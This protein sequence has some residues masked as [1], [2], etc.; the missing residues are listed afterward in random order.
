MEVTRGA[1]PLLLSRV[2]EGAP[3]PG[4]GAPLVEVLSVK[5]LESAERTALRCNFSDGEFKHQACILENLV[6]DQANAPATVV[7]HA[8]VQLTNWQL[9]L[10][11]TRSGQTKPVLTIERMVVL[12]TVPPEKRTPARSLKPAHGGPDLDTQCTQAVPETQPGHPSEL[13]PAAVPSV[14]SSSSVSAA[15]GVA[16][17]PWRVGTTSAVESD[18]AAA[19]IAGLAP[20]RGNQQLTDFFNRGPS[21]PPPGGSAAAAAAL[22]PPPVQQADFAAS[23]AAA[24]TARAAAVGGGAV[25]R[26]VQ[27]T[28]LPIR[29]LTPYQ[30]G[31]WRIKAR[32]IAKESIRRFTNSRGE[33]Q[34]FKVELVDKDGAEINATFFGRAVD[35]YFEMI[36]PMQVY[37]FS[38]GQVKAANKRFDKGDVVITFDDGAVI[39]VAE[40]DQGIRGV[41]YQFVPIAEI[42]QR[43]VQTDIDVKG[44]ITEVRDCIT[45]MLRTS[46]KERAKREIVL[47]DNSGGSP[48]SFIEMAMWGDIA[49]KE[50]EV[51]TVMFARSARVSEW[52]N[53]KQLN[54]S[55]SFELNP[56]DAQAFGLQRDYE[57]AGR[58][59]FAKAGGYGGVPGTQGAYQGV[60]MGMRKTLDQC[61]EEDLNL[62]PPPI[63]G[64]AL[65][66]SG[67]KSV[68][69]HMVVATLTC[70]PTERQ[71]FYM[72]CPELVERQ[73][74]G[75]QGAAGDARPCQKKMTQEGP[76][77]WRCGA[78]HCVA[79]PIARYL[80]QRV[81]VLDHSGS[82]EVNFF[83]ECG[84][85][86]FQCEANQVA[87][88]WEDPARETEKD[89]LLGG[90]SWRRMLFRLRSARETWNEEERLKITADDAQP[91][92]FAKEA[93]TM[94][95]DI[96]FAVQQLG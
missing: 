93:R 78:G 64:Q 88:C 27:G 11:S 46:Q 65:D 60:S 24:A 94:L 82:L 63:P 86:V 9:S 29:E 34:L 51:G 75:S 77:T 89:A 15:A 33:G 44:V 59:Q 39:E 52:Q 95:S 38:R 90:A 3:R 22:T 92:D 62:G 79:A 12:G 61:R 83:D 32:V 50:Y 67:P 2:G 14:G 68:H 85:K 56:D 66:P 76:G 8:L 35:K 91:I 47:W 70:I 7:Q 26:P 49:Q 40:E 30:Q 16:S 18:A 53:A 20:P 4:E 69:R 13:P 84:K 81:S 5:K 41:T 54:F 42:A 43:E 57:A 31:R 28:F 80:C 58:P 36:R 45:V 1:L 19:S 96:Q 73:I 21:T 6:V 37:T 23:L 72:A 25:G 74:R 17:A 55:G 10:V 87:Q 48:G 71:P